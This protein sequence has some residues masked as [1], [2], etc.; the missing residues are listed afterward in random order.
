MRTV[1]RRQ[2]AGSL[3]IVS[4]EEAPLSQ[5]APSGADLLS[6]LPKPRL[7]DLGR[8]F[9]VAIAKPNGV[10]I[11]ESVERLVESGQLVFRVLLEWMRRDELRKACKTFGLNDKERSRS[12]LAGSLLG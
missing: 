12:A 9:G 11:T 5:P 2:A 1:T 6:T 8:Q 7:V 4:N 3:S 10:P